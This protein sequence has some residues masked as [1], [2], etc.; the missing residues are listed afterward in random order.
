MWK[1]TKLQRNQRPRDMQQLRRQ[2]TSNPHEENQKDS[3][4]N[5][6]ENKTRTYINREETT[7][8]KK[9]VVV[10]PNTFSKDSEI[11]NSFL[12]CFV[13]GVFPFKTTKSVL[14]GK[15][16]RRSY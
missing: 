4:Q 6:E 3:S 13:F 5:H 12:D 2:S 15:M 10:L 9:T 11:L 1:P 14:G 7:N 8:T 16:N